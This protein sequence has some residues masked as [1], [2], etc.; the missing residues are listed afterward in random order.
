[1]RQGLNK[2]QAALIAVVVLAGAVAVLF[3]GQQLSQT[4]FLHVESWTSAEEFQVTEELFCPGPLGYS[5]SVGVT[6]PGETVGV[7]FYAWKQ[8]RV[9]LPGPAEFKLIRVDEEGNPLGVVDQETREIKTVGSGRVGWETKVLEGAPAFYRFGVL[10]RDEDGGVFGK[11]VSTL[12]VPRQELNAEL[13]LNKKEFRSVETLELTILNEGPTTLFF[14]V[15]YTAEYLG[16]D[17]V[18]R[19]ASWLYPNAWISIGISLQPG[20]AYNQSIELFPVLA[21]TYRI[22]KEVSAE[23]TN[24]S[25]TLTE[26]FTVIEGTPEDLSTEKQAINIGRHFLDGIGYVTGDVSFAELDKKTPNFYWHELAELE[27]PGVQG[28]R[29]CWVVRFEQARRPG[30]WFEVWI[31]AQTGEVI[32]G[33]QCR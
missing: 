4:N 18:W 32:G 15:D 17:G 16:D 10:I 30:H 27:K 1:V 21:G 7:H 11:L 23:G 31:D 29:P 13:S 33:M 19:E 22:S 9:D 20:K 12:Y 14:G 5:I 25:R 28:L 24:I 8:D 6:E 2:P 3:T 26:S